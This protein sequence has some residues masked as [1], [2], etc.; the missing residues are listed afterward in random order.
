MEASDDNASKQ[1]NQP[2][3]VVEE[4][5]DTD[6]DD[7]NGGILSPQPGG[8]RK[9]AKKQRKKPQEPPKNEVFSLQHHTWKLTFGPGN[10]SEV[11]GGK[12]WEENDSIVHAA[13]L[14]AHPESIVTV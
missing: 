12:V 11:Y 13:Q 2:E 1:A 9:R 10:H 6:V 5:A 7:A 14:L 4:E 3:Y 8:E